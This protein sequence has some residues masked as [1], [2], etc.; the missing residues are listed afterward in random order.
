V[1]HKK[2]LLRSLAHRLFQAL[3]FFGKYL[4]FISFIVP[5]NQ[6]LYSHHL[7]L[8]QQLIEHVTQ[9]TL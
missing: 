2:P 6:W 1:T 3:I 8:Q 7:Y 9:P 5:D 4:F